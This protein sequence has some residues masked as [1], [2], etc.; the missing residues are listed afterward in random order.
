[1]PALIL[2]CL[3]VC[4]ALLF[5]GC[6]PQAT[7]LRV[8]TNLW[9][10]YEPLYLA[11]AHGLFRA[12]AMR[13]VTM[14]NATEVQ[15]ALRAG[16]LEVAA[17]T[18]DEVFTV[19]QDGADLKVILVMD[20]SAGADV[21][22]ARPSFTSVK[23]LAG[24]RIGVESTAVGAVM[25]QSALESADLPASRVKLIP[26]PVEQHVSA[27]QAGKV[28]ALVTFEPARSQLLALGGRT[29]F[30]SRQIPG[31]IVDVLVTTPQVAA[32]R[33]DELRALIAGFFAMNEYRQREP[34]AAASAMAPRLGLSSTEV[35]A[36]YGGIRVP[37]PEENR[38]ML[39]PVGAIRPPAQALMQVMLEGGLLR[40]PVSLDGLFDDRFLPGR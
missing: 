15:Q 33:G 24:R 29:L 38:Q 13:M 28:D 16:V 7:P 18:L 21:L 1:M 37:S 17:L 9:I 14:R 30:D 27:Y 35:L 4:V 5:Q 36:A 39:R 23:A 32:Q 22:I 34:E 25:L 10:G 3:I 26:V 2:R 6:A 20:V 8:G 19:L 40:H 12:H 31:R 11:E